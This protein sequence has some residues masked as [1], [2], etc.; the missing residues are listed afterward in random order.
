MNKNIENRIKKI[1]QALSIG[2]KQAIVI[3]NFRRYGDKPVA[4]TL[5]PIEQWETY[6]RAIAEGPD[7][8]LIIFEADPQKE[9]EARKRLQ[10]ETEG[11]NNA[12]H[13]NVDG[14]TA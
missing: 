13:P 4:D 10:N 11:N 5:G 7:G 3:L 6:K 12:K 2:E 9:I 8:D 14:Q 1:E